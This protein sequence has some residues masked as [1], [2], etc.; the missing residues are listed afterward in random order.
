MNK[1][2]FTLIELIVSIILVS[3]VLISMTGTLVKL[4]DTY[5]VVN[6]DADARIYG[7][8]ISKIVND[9]LLKNTTLISAGDGTKINPFRV[10]VS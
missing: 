8:T 2:G 9:D 3:I 6:E 10:K 5:S 7:A 4:K 1:K